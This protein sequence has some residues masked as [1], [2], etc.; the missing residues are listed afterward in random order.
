MRAVIVACVVVLGACPS[1][2]PNYPYTQEPD[3]RSKEIDLGIGDVLEIRVWDQK[4]LSTDPT[5]RP[6]GMITMPLIGDVK[7]AAET[8][9]GLTKTIELKL[10]DFLKLGASNQV[11][12]ALKQWKSYTWRVAGEVQREGQYT[13]DRFVTVADALAMAGGV[14][15]FAKRGQIVLLRTDPKTQ[16]Q[17]EIPFD[18]DTLASGKKPEMN[19]W[20]LAGDAI[21]VP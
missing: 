20:I 1:R 3:P 5:V 9:S 2:I 15:R 19:I 7:A 21:Y 17:K 13:A 6:D 18:Y 4:D 8:P 14:T 10:K 12:V 11:T 16:K